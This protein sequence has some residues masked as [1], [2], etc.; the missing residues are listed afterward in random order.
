MD[1][2]GNIT[3]AFHQ[4]HTA[5]GLTQVIVKTLG[6]GSHA[7]LL[8]K[9]LITRTLAQE[10]YRVGEIHQP[11][12]NPLRS[13]WSHTVHTE[14]IIQ[15]RQHGLLHCW[16]Q[17][18]LLW[19]ASLLRSDSVPTRYKRKMNQ[20]HKGTTSSYSTPLYQV[21]HW[22]QMLA[23]GQRK[24]CSRHPP[25]SFCGSVQLASSLLQLLRAYFKKGKMGYTM[26]HYQDYIHR[27]C[28]NWS[29]THQ[30]SEAVCSTWMHCLEQAAVTL[31]PLSSLLHPE[32]N[33][34]GIKRHLTTLLGCLNAYSH[35]GYLLYSYTFLTIGFR[36][37]IV[38]LYVASCNLR[39]FNTIPS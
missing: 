34:M 2:K 37:R 13:Y 39:A 16:S 24:F 14:D 35:V 30:N 38:C 17:T 28:I 15:S 9:H 10:V 26:T 7:A 20:I 22:P 23:R 11:A 36:I 4:N 21:R 12:W 6:L 8:L 29:L 33:Y 1:P 3:R 31:K 27:I 19:K 18:A 32:H 5:L 25:C